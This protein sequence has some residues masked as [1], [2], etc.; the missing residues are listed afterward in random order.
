MHRKTNINYD[1]VPFNPKNNDLVEF[2]KKRKEVKDGIRSRVD[3]FS[4]KECEK[5][6]NEDIKKIVYKS[7][8]HD[9]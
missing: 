4:L 1:I 7:K 9:K 5:Q 8:K 2:S 6:L 3:K